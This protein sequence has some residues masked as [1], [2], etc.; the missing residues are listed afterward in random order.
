M[1]NDRPTV[2]ELLNGP[3][4]RPTP[5]PPPAAPPR[6][7]SPPGGGDVLRFG[8]VHQL[9]M[10]ADAADDVA[11]DLRRGLRTATPDTGRAVRA[12]RDGF[13]AA[14]ALD[15]AMAGWQRSVRKLTDD[16]EGLAPRLT[17]TAKDLRDAEKANVDDVNALW[18]VRG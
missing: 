11:A 4:P 16:V 7:S 3:T 2:G 12:M 13:T 17:K 6:A 8:D 14:T 15:G 18:R 5:A 1:P 10:G 9:E